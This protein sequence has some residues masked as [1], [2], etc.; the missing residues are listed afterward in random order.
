MIDT[1]S[2]AMRTRIDDIATSK[3]LDIFGSIYKWRWWLVTKL[4]GFITLTT[5]TSV[6]TTLIIETRTSVMIFDALQD[7]KQE[8]TV[9]SQT[10]AI[11]TI[12]THS[13]TT[14]DLFNDKQQCPWDI[15]DS[16]FWHDSDKSTGLVDYNLYLTITTMSLTRSGMI[17]TGPLV[18]SKGKIYWTHMV[19]LQMSNAD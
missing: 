2:T 9:T 8:R 7:W 14:N 1:L 11:I 17:Q 4:E 18:W 6:T 5:D 16:T 3:Q 13:P 15:L 12:E 10:S 19:F